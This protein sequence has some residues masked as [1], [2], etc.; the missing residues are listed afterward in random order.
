MT[1]RWSHFVRRDGRAAAAAQSGFTLM[2]VLV[3]LII[4]TILA[5]VVGVNVL[6]KP[7]EARMAAA[8][9]QIKSLQTALA[10][11]KTEQG[12]FPTQEQGL[13]ALCLPPTALPVPEHYPEGGYLE[14]RK[15]PLDP[16]GHEYVYL[17]PGRHGEPY[18]IVTYGSDGEPEGKGEAADISSS[19]L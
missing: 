19:D 9:V 13:D 6:H 12:Q 1:S 8:R 18:E 11:Y 5:T 7:G 10:M 14:T 15:V 16:W 2:E 3:V 4:I 17:V